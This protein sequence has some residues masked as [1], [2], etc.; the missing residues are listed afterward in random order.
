MLPGRDGPH[1]GT[2]ILE[3]G[4]GD[5]VTKPL[6]VRSIAIAGRPCC[7][8]RRGADE[9]GVRSAVSAVSA[10]GPSSGDAATFPI[11]MRLVTS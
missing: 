7:A 9:A 10:R 8:A 5:Y 6:G 2:P 11:A 4:A 3:S 1:R